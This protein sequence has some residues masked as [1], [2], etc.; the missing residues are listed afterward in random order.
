MFG[1]LTWNL[2]VVSKI[3]SFS[4]LP[5]YFLCIFCL[6]Y[7]PSLLLISFH[8]A[9]VPFHARSTKL[10]TVAHWKCLLNRKISSF[11]ADVVLILFIFEWFNQM[12]QLSYCSQ[13]LYFALGAMKVTDIDPQRC[14]IDINGA[15]FI[16]HSPVVISTSYIVL[17]SCVPNEI[18][19]VELL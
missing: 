2:V 4:P 17:V 3:F 8:L 13:C 9:F 12:S 14:L 18:F 11:D 1:V 6:F 15:G 5:V 19:M 7:W 10:K 16:L